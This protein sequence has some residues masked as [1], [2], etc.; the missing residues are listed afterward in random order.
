MEA[1]VLF[2]LHLNTYLHHK[3]FFEQP[4][5][6]GQGFSWYLFFSSIIQKTC[7]ADEWW[8]HWCFNNVSYIY[9]YLINVEAQEVSP[10]LDKV[11]GSL[12]ILELQ[13]GAWIWECVGFSVFNLPNLPAPKLSPKNSTDMII[14]YL[15]EHGRMYFACSWFHAHVARMN[16]RLIVAGLTCNSSTNP[17]QK[18][19]GLQSKT[20]KILQR[21]QWW[22]SPSRRMERNGCR[23]LGVQMVH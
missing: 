11:D 9:I 4:H 16:H 20:D 6:N 13:T 22:R 10:T 3:N 14:W 8:T 18:R 2:F 21:E 23:G 17:W 5:G 19:S 7:D 1:N 15:E 12:W